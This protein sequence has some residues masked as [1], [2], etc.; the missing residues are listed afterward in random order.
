MRDRT[1][2]GAGGFWMLR[3]LLVGVFSWLMTG[4]SAQATMTLPMRFDEIVR[5]SGQAFVGRCVSLDYGIDENGIPAAYIEFEVSQ[6]IK[7]VSTDRV[8][9]KQYGLIPQ[10]QA[11]HLLPDVGYYE[12][13][14]VSLKTM[15]GSGGSYRIDE[16]LVLFLYPASKLGFSSPV[17]FGQGL[18][19]VRRTHDGR[20]YVA[21]SFQNA[22][23]GRIGKPNASVSA[24]QNNHSQLTNALELDSLLEWASRLREGS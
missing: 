8:T 4:G 16:E 13:G 10:P 6:P 21:N 15:Q 19:R 17:G 12:S 22:F 7:G 18:F 5:Q 24:Y 23:L 14:I 9:L 1:R 3:V 2:L 11:D 20:E